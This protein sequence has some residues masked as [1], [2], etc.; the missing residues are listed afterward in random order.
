MGLELGSIVSGKVTGITKFGAFVALD[1]ESGVTGLVHISE[2][3]HSYVNDIAEHL[4]V[5]QEVKVKVMSVGDGGRV[6]LSIKKA[7]EPPPRENTQ[8]PPRREG[9]GGFSRQPQKPA[10]P[11]TFEDR[12]SKFMQDSNKNLSGMFTEKKRRRRD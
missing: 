12:L 10:E 5:G 8:R 4:Q 11:E 6:S 9:G 3:S 1:G 2:V 7:T